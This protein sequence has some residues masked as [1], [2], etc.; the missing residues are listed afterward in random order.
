M[1]NFRRFLT[2]ETSSIDVL[3]KRRAWE[4]ILESEVDKQNIVR[5]VT[6]IE[7][8]LRDFQV[9]SSSVES[10]TD[11]ASDRCCNVH[12]EKHRGNDG[13]IECARMSKWP[14]IS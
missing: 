6:R 1:S 12:R 8:Q 7:A 3:L 4:R 14:G 2:E 11:T 9:R 5:V 13:T 10:D